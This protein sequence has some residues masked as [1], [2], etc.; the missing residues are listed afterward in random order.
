MILLPSIEYVSGEI[1]QAALEYFTRS[2]ADRGAQ[3]A[4]PGAGALTRRSNRKGTES[5]ENDG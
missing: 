4:A 5:A 3:S 1:N 2:I